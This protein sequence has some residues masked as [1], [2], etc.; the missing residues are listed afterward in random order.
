VNLAAAPPLLVLA[1][2]LLSSEEFLASSA[3]SDSA[4]SF[5]DT[6]RTSRSAACVD[7]EKLSME[8]C[9]TVTGSSLRAESDDEGDDEGDRGAGGMDSTEGGAEAMGGEGVGRWRKGGF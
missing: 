7:R 9:S 6:S 1:A 2:S 5:S 8:S 3:F 4:M